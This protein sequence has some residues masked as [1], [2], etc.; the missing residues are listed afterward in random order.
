[1]SWAALFLSRCFRKNSD[2]LAWREGIG[3]A[4]EIL[5]PQSGIFGGV[6]VMAALEAFNVMAVVVGV[7]V[8]VAVTPGT[9]FKPENG[10]TSVGVSTPRLASG[11]RLA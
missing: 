4:V 8:Q 11:L 6:Q 5:G 2:G 1:M 3:F 10:R 9:A 7:V